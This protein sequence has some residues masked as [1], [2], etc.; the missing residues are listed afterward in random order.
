MG[1]RPSFFTRPPPDDR[2]AAGSASG[3][4]AGVG[5]RISVRTSKDHAGIG[6]SADKAVA[7]LGRPPEVG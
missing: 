6:L 7:R 4:D 2:L 3:G 1:T 5:R